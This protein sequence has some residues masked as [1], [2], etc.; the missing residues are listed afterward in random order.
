[1]K[2]KLLFGAVVA[3]LALGLV[4]CKQHGDIN[5]GNKGSGDGTQTYKVKQTND[6][7]HTIR[8][9]TRFDIIPRHQATC[10]V[11]QFDQTDD[12]C[13]GMVGFITYYTENKKDLNAA[14]YGTINFLVVG[15]RNNC[16]STETYASYYCNIHTDQLSTENFGAGTNKKDKYDPN[17][18]EPYEVII[19]DLPGT[20]KNPTEGILSKKYDKTSKTLEIAIQFSGNS[21]G[22]IDIAWYGSWNTPAASQ[23]AAKIDFTGKMPLLTK[24]ATAEQIGNE[25]DESDPKAKAKKGT[26]WA[27]ANIYYDKVKKEGKTLNASWDLYNVSW[28]PASYADEDEPLTVGEIFF[29]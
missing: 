23:A 11:K 15:V 20:G 27:Y 5:F 8:G 9:M 26:I 16:G 3:A 10:V 14:N 1:M 22:S 17:A 18:T 13:D 19:V 25:V 7:D 2:K 21:D 28:S 6:K 29:E 12:S 4:A 24:Q